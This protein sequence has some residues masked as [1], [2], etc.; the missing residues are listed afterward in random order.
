MDFF[1]DLLDTLPDAIC[2]IDSRSY[3]IKYINKT[4]S[5]DLM[6]INNLKDKDFVD[7]VIEQK[8]R[9]KFKVALST[10][11]MTPNE[12][13]VGYCQ[14]LALIGDEK[15]PVHKSYYWSI[16]KINQD[17]FA[18]RGILNHEKYH[19]KTKTDMD[20]SAELLDFF[21]NA[22]ISLHWLTGTGH[23]LW[24]NNM[25]LGK[26]IYMYVYKL[27]HAAHIYSYYSYT[28]TYSHCTFTYPHLFILYMYS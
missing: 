16:S 17:N 8:D 4:F 15:F 28:Y 14:S 11:C 26:C 18:I 25:E 19:T 13:E 23:I 6:N 7:N 3:T 21:Q 1:S 27:T 12:V 22:P 20:F 9:S 10:V 2:V 24:A 5:D